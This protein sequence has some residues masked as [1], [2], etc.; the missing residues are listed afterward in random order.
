MLLIFKNLLIV[1]QLLYIIRVYFFIVVSN[2]NKRTPS[3]PMKGKK[4]VV[5]AKHRKLAYSAAI[6]VF[7]F[8]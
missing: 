8:L 3:S 1:I 5:E 6:T 7:V 4:L 2:V